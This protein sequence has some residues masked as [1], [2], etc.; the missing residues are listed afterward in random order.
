MEMQA[1]KRLAISQLTGGV[2]RDFNNLLQIVGG[3]LQLL[4]KDVAGNERAEMRL[5]NARLACL[6]ALDGIVTSG[7]WT[8]STA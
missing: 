6:A 7:V 8:P 3:N 2:A 4:G 1:Q 5:G